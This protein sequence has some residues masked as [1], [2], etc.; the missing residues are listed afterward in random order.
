MA[1]ITKQDVGMSSDADKLLIKKVASLIT[2]LIT[3]AQTHQT[4]LLAYYTHELAQY[5]NRYYSKNRVINLEDIA[6]SRTRL[7]LVTIIRQTLAICL[8]L[9]GLSK[10]TR[11]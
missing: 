9:L 10:P 2:I 5:F 6:L 7:A 8:D 4:H 11:M 3:I 1:D